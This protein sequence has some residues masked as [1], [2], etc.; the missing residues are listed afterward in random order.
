LTG[1][2]MHGAMEV[3]DGA[4]AD[5]QKS[6]DTLASSLIT[7]VNQV[8]SAGFS[9][10]GSTG[11]AFFT[12]TNAATIGV[13]TALRDNPALIQAS[14]VSGAAGDNQVALAL[15]QLGS[16]AQ[17]G[18]A[19]QT[20]GQHYGQTTAALGNAMVD[21]NQKLGDQQMV[22]NWLTQQRDSI[23][24]VSLDEEMTELVKYQKAF[25]ASARLVNTVDEMLD[26]VLSLK[27]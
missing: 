2:S 14:G 26:T 27:R 6:L 24:G 15:A 21:V 9:L 23:S 20:F 3:R 10:T 22:E 18:L 5:L 16:K 4:I 25:E 12:G 17:A 1:G 11:A 7:Q 13:N 8:H 19:N